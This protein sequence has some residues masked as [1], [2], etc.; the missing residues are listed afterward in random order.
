MRARMVEAAGEGRTIKEIEK[1]LEKLGINVLRYDPRPAEIR[2]LKELYKQMSACVID[3]EK[4]R[5]ATEDGGPQP[6]VTAS[7]QAEGGLW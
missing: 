6:I 7:E 4:E 3:L 1:L 5:R 2:K